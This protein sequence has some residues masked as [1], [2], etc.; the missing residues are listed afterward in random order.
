MARQDTP[1][2][3]RIRVASYNIH[4]CV[5][6]DGHRSPERVAA[7]LA[8]IDADVIGLQEVDWRDDPETGIPQPDL[9]ATLSDYR[10]LLG[11]NLKDHRG[12]YGNMLL[13]RGAV[14]AVRRID[15]RYPARE[16]RGAIEAAIETGG[17]AFR[18]VATH[19]G[20]SRAE[21]RAQ[22]DLL[23][24]TVLAGTTDPVLLVGDFN[25]WLPAAGTLRPLHTQAHS[26]GHP[27]TFPAQW[28]LIAL[29][30]MMARGLAAAGPVRAHRTALSRRAS[31]H[32]PI[33]ADIVDAPAD[34]TTA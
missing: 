6:T 13:V 10:A 18:A 27:A 7:V 5:G 4:R 30:R 19:F 1:D 34:K 12:H 11:P 33:V 24:R 2:R 22:A 9:L 15:L 16:P 8:E 23:A 3:P 17:L 21:R 32:L 29:D 26:L 14:G 28:P 20:L 25:E 31:D